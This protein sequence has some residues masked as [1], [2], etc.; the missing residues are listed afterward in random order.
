MRSDSGAVFYQCPICGNGLPLEPPVRRFEAP[1][2]GCGY[3][4]WCRRRFPS[5]DTELEALPQRTPEPGDLHPLVEALVQKGAHTRVL[6]DLSRLDMVDT[7]FVAGLVSLNKLLHAAGG[8]LVLQGLCPLVRE[9]FG[10]FRFDRVLQIA[11]GMQRASRN[12]AE[13]SLRTSL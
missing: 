1:C 8:E 11:N 3:H 9:V 10:H 12:P 5:G 13:T 7:R 6:V 4:L 2:S